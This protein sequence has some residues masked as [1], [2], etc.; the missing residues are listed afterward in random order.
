MERLTRIEYDDY[1]ANAGLTVLQ[2]EI[3]RMRYFDPTEP[4]I[5]SI[6]MTLNISETKFH[7]NRRKLLAQIFKYEQ[8]KEKNK[9]C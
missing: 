4:T 7:R 8:L 2:K 9:K 3:L 6:C 1:I 5:T